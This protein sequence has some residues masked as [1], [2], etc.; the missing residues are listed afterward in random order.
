MSQSPVEWIHL[1][2]AAPDALS[3]GDLVSADAGGLPTYR[4]IALAERQVFLR[5]EARAASQWLPLSRLHWKMAIGRR[6]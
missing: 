2:V 4:V 1:D 6:D 5:D 3:I